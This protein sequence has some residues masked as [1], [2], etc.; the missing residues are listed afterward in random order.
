MTIHSDAFKNYPNEIFIETGSLN[1][2]GIQKAL[3]AG[4]KRIISIEI[5]EHYYEKCKKRFQNNPEVELI[6]GDSFK[7]LPSVIKDINVP[8][9]FWLDG[10]YS[11]G[12]TGKGQYQTPLIQEI[13]VIASH[14]L[15][16]HTIL[17]DDM[18]CWKDPNH[19]HGFTVDDIFK[20]LDKIKSDYEVSYINGHIE[21]D[22]MVVQFN[23][24]G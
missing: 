23:L 5:T 24:G 8:I 7:I 12:D 9:T 21:N 16:N 1:G 14:P 11:W 10:H 19:G 4:F 13:E 3:N 22:I 2:D 18:R 15:K 6:K 20:A 17:I